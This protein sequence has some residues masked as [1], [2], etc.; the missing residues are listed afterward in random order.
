MSARLARLRIALPVA[1]ILATVDCTTKE[2]AVNLLS[3]GRALHPLLGGFVRFTLA[4]NTQ[5]AMSMPTGPF[6]RPL[7]T[8]AS[9]V[10]IG[11]LLRMLWR[12]PL[13]DRWYRLSVGLILGGAISN[14]ASRAFSPRGVVDFLDLGVGAHRFFICN[15]ADI[16]VCG[17][18]ALLALLLWRKG[19]APSWPHTTSG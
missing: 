10:I 4:F 8:L 9:L 16:G 2:L 17:G 5:A 6:G 18:A 7:L 19:D 3:P 1:L 15:V 13:S 11:V 14:L 12:A